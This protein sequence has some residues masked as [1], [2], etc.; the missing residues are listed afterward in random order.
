MEKAQ[1]FRSSYILE[2][3]SLTPPPAAFLYA[4][5]HVYS[6]GARLTHVCALNSHVHVQITDQ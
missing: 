1:I 2:T 4:A 3:L 6:Q 5:L